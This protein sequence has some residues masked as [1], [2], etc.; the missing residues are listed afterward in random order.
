MVAGMT[1]VPGAHASV[2]VVARRRSPRHPPFDVCGARVGTIPSGCG[3]GP[4]GYVE[5]VCGLVVCASLELP[6]VLDGMR[7]AVVV[8]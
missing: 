2:L 4:H 5:S 1:T 3:R 8:V 6:Y 7:C